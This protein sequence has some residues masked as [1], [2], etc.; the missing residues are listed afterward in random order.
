MMKDNGYVSG[1]KMCSSGGKNYDE[2]I[3]NKSSHELIK[4]LG[5]ALENTHGDSE[6]QNST[7]G[8]SDCG[9]PQ[10]VS[11]PCISAMASNITDVERVI[12]GTYYH[13]VLQICR[14][15]SCNTFSSPDILSGV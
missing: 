9:I 11:K 10:S 13:P 4:A 12:S 15:V 3:K 8:D 7:L 5:K 1:T 6:N 14:G 2:W